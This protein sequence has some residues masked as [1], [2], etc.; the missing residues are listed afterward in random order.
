MVI[1]HQSSEGLFLS[2]KNI[3]IMPFNTFIYYLEIQELNALD[4]KMQ[5]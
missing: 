1:D 3:L 5:D 2:N 4:D